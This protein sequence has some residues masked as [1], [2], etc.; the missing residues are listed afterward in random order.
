MSIIKCLAWFTKN[1]LSLCSFAQVSKAVLGGQSGPRKLEVI[2]CSWQ[3]WT[4]FHQYYTASLHRHMDS[5][6]CLGGLNLQMFLPL[7]MD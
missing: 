1:T 5:R 7:E 2:Y 4:C 6:K 3:V